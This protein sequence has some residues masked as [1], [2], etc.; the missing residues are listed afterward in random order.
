LYNLTQGRKFSYPWMRMSNY[1]LNCILN[2]LRGQGCHDFH[3]VPADQGM[4]DGCI[5][6]FRRD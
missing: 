4:A 5:F 3:L 2:V 1:S 6:F